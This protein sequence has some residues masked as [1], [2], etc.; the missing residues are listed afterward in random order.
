MSG[1]SEYTHA[2]AERAVPGSAICRRHGTL[3]CATA[4]TLAS[5]QAKQDIGLR[6]SF[7]VAARS[8]EAAAIG[9]LIGGFAGGLEG[10]IFVE[11]AA[12]FIADKFWPPEDTYT[13][14]HAD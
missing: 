14:A 2:R 8:I 10:S 13:E 11:E 7:E 12:E 4:W 3:S 6:S 5:I 9:G 1:G